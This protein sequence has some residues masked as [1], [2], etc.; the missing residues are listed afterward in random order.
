MMNDATLYQLDFQQ[1]TIRER[2]IHKGTSFL[3]DGRRLGR[4]HEVGQEPG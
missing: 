2:F 4:P 1:E 3:G